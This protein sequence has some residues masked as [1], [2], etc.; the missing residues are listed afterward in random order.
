MLWAEIAFWVGTILG[1]AA[2]VIGI[3]AIRKR[4]RRGLG[5]TGMVLAVLGPVIFWVVLVVA[6]GAGTAAG[7]VP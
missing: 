1:I 6:L 2:I 3:I 5:I 4:Q 7:F